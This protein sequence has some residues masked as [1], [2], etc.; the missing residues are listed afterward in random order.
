MTTPG[1]GASGAP[2]LPVRSSGRVD[3]DGTA[4]VR[5][6]APVR[7]ADNP[8]VPDLSRA[9]VDLPALLDRGAD[10]LVSR[11]P[12]GAV[13]LAELL[14]RAR[15]ALVRGAPMEVLAALDAGWDGA[16]RTESGWYFRAAA[17]TLLGLPGEAERVLQQAAPVREGSAA[18][19]FLQSVVHSVRGHAPGAR[20]ALAEAL[21]HRPGEPLLRAWDAV[22]SARGG[23]TPTALALLHE[24]GRGG[25]SEPVIAWARQAIQRAS[26]NEQR[27]VRL[28]DSAAPAPAATSPTVEAD[29]APPVAPPHLEPIDAALGRL[30]ARLGTASHGEL[31]VDV[32]QLMQSLSA[33]G[34][35]QEAGRSERSHAVRAVLAT[36][37]QLLGRSDGEAGGAPSPKP[38]GHALDAFPDADG[39][40]RLT[41]VGGRGIAPDALVAPS[42]EAPLLRR[43]VLEALRAGRPA[44]ADQ[45]LGQARAIESESVVRVLQRLIAGAAARDHH[46]P[47]VVGGE[48]A[49]AVALTA[50][51]DET[52]LSPLRFGL[53]LLHEFVPRRAGR[54]TH[55]SPA[56]VGAV[57]ATSHD[58]TSSTDRD[59]RASS[60]RRVGRA[61]AV[62]CLLLATLALLLGNG[63]VAL[64]LAGGAVW[65]LLR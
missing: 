33:S 5:P 28:V 47:D 55:A 42:A 45:L 31:A 58:G 40:W 64:L 27:A 30:G 65:L 35:L 43:A 13:A 41:P 59:D 57:R 20:A 14:E 61:V 49:S 23:N 12:P 36:L 29:V 24:L 52:L 11:E 56:A 38:L 3:M 34:A 1:V 6:V 15:G 10:A 63:T 62:G 50:S 48:P 8:L 16:A 51:R 2:L 19:A 60:V 7:P 37:Q 17:L 44:D 26:A 46:V 32:R 18:L 22:L 4:L 53:I 9:G 54:V 39:R 21:A 25:H